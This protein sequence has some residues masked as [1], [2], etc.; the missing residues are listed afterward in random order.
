MAGSAR[1]TM[2]SSAFI[3]KVLPLKASLANRSGLLEAE[4][5]LPAV[6]RLAD[7]HVIKHLDLENPSSF[8]ESPSQ[9]KISFARARVAGYA[10]CGI[11]PDGWLCTGMKEFAE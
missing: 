8:V 3:T 1:R 5:S 11:A 7:D 9:A 6:H 2:I 10:A 4:I